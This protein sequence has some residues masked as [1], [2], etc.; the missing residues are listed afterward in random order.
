MSN[1]PTMPCP[2]CWGAKHDPDQ[3]Q[4]P[5]RSC[6]GIGTVKDLPLSPHFRLSEVVVSQTAIRRQ[7]P[8]D[9]PIAVAFALQQLATGLLD[10][11]RDLTGPLHVDSGYRSPEL[12]LAVGGALHSAHTT[13]SA[14]DLKPLAP[15]VTLRRLMDLARDLPVPYDQVIW[16]YGAWVHVAQ[17]GPGNVQ[18]RQALMIFPGGTYEPFS[19]RDPRLLE[20]A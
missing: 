6:R 14:A 18:R 17:F 8:N 15:G 4:A 12:N 7:I 20:A 19:A 3:P 2:R 10:P 1:E 16:E 5:C 11:L 9:P 13:G